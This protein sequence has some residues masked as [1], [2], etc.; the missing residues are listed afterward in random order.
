MMFH[1]WMD[2]LLLLLC[3]LIIN[4]NIIFIIRFNEHDDDVPDMAGGPGG[5]AAFLLFCHGLTSQVSAGQEVIVVKGARYDY[6]AGLFA[7]EAQ[8]SSAHFKRLGGADSNEFYPYLYQSTE[9]RGTWVL[10]W[11]NEDNFEERIAIFRAP[12]GSNGEN[13]PPEKG[14]QYVRDGSNDGGKSRGNEPNLRVIKVQLDEEE[15][16]ASVHKRGGGETTNGVICRTGRGWTNSEFWSHIMWDDLEFCHKTEACE[17]VPMFRWLVVT[18]TDGKDGIYKRNISIGSLIHLDGDSTIY[19]NANRWLI[20]DDGSQPDRGSAYYKTRE[21]DRG[22]LASSWEYVF[23]EG[24]KKGK[25]CGTPRPNIHVLRAPTEP[26][27]GNLQTEKGF[28]CESRDE[29]NKW[30]WMPGS[31]CDEKCQC[32]EKCIEGCDVQH[33]LENIR[34]LVVRGPYSQQ[35]GALELNDNFNPH[36]FKHLEEE[37]LVF[38]KDGSWVLGSGSNPKN[39]TKVHLTAKQGQEIPQTGWMEGGRTVDI[40]RVNI[41]PKEFTRDQMEK[42]EENK[43]EGFFCDGI[44]G[45]RLFITKQGDDPFFC[46]G[47]F[48]CKIPNTTVATKPMDERFCSIIADVSIEGPIFTTSGAV[49]CGIVLFLAVRCCLMGEIKKTDNKKVAQGLKS[50]VDAIIEKADGMS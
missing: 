50:L 2:G 42:G 41:V 21:K 1:G 48:D 23:D 12:A 5:L 28:T 11:A 34:G 37:L 39:V 3:N 6:Y 18:G 4:I 7:E 43:D 29:H 13:T 49:A 31:T 44:N 46:D 36:F 17:S 33:V 20:A 8:G 27:D 35:S 45:N 32:H 47:R 22:L 25:D 19:K 26:K 10:S 38:R 15:T 40:M 14:W 9:Q 24:D 16:A 30:L